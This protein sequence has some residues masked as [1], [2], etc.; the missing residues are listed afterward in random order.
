MSFIHL[1]PYTLALAI[2]F[3]RFSNSSIRPRL[4]GCSSLVVC[5]ITATGFQCLESCLDCGLVACTNSL[6]YLIPSGIFIFHI[7]DFL[8]LFRREEYFVV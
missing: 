4:V 3:L 1:E 2:L 7:Q 8:I 5:C 6:K